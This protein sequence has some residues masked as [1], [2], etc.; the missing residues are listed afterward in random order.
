V[1]PVPW[2]GHGSRCPASLRPENLPGLLLQASYGWQGCIRAASAVSAKGSRTCGRWYVCDAILERLAQDFQDVACALGPFIE[3]E[4]AAVRRRHLP[5]P[6][7]LTAADEP[8]I[9]DGLV[10]ARKGRVVTRAVRAPV[11]PA[12]RWMRVVSRSSA[13]VIACRLV[14]RR[15]ASL[16]VP[17]P[18]G[19]G[20]G[21][22]RQNAFEVLSVT[23]PSRGANNHPGDPSSEGRKTGESG[24]RQLL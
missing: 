7:H 5:R 13:T 16:D 9:R 6:R 17:A 24:L 10:G 22:D 18:A 1:S 11:R 4:P 15:L 14:V 8:H 20:V 19:P 23:L 3:E 12:T 21:R 2:G